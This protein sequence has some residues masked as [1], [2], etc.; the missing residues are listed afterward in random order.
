MA[1]PLDPEI[2][3]RY[4]L[5]PLQLHDKT[6]FDQAFASVTERITDY[7]FANTFMWHDTLGIYW[8]EIEGFLCVFAN[9]T[10]DLT[11]FLPPLGT[12]NLSACLKQC[13][14]IMDDFNSRHADRSHSRIEY[15]SDSMLPGLLEAGLV[16][17]P[18]G[19]DYI[20]D[21]QL[22]IDL[23]GGSL[24]NKRQLRNRFMREHAV[25]TELLRPE[26]VPLCI[27]LLHTWQVQGDATHHDTWSEHAAI[28]RKHDTKATEVVLRNFESLGLTGMVVWADDRLAGFTLG[29]PLSDRQVSILIEKT[30]RSLDGSA[31]FIFSEFCRQVWHGYAECNAGDD[32]GLP[33][34]RWTKQSY[35]PIRLLGKHVVT[36]VATPLI[37]WVPEV[38][39][40][41]QNPPHLPV[42]DEAVPAPAASEDAI[43]IEVATEADLPGLIH[44]EQRVFPAGEAFTPK[45]L[46][47]LIRTSR[48]LIKVARVN[49]QVVGWAIALIRRHKRTQ[50]ARLYSLAVDPGYQGR[51]LGKRLT[52]DLLDDLEGMGIKRCFLEV[53]DDNVKAQQL[54]SHLGFTDVTLLPNYYGEGQ[55]GRKMLR[56]STAPVE[57]LAAASLPRPV[58]LS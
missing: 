23:P 35:H 37:G 46:R 41:V 13:F 11:M 26:H 14:E 8:K 34:L 57:S 36:S 44:L 28:L 9:S 52:T 7:T 49:G 24:K 47:Y 55:H 16:S 51:G 1:S 12:G 10:G 4:A 2:R 3:E 45:Q 30:D 27:S 38:E 54:Y 31:Q 22:M 15:V 6:R 19:G 29:E 17:S 39:L 50:S 25:R 48:S 53:R 40:P 21:M 5:N 32:W 20:Y 33:S 56:V 58:G 43:T 18:M 42:V